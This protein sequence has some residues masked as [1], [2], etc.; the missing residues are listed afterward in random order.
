MPQ[1]PDALVLDEPFVGQDFFNVTRMMQD[2][3]AL[4]DEGKTIV[5]VS[6]DIDMV[7]RYCDRI[8]LFSGGRVVAEGQPGAVAQQIV[9]LGFREYVPEGCR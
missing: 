3:E 1:G 8:V 7:Y 2:L 4:R 5:I 9:A 6:H